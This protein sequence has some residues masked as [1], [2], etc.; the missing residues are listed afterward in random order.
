MRSLSFSKFD[1]KKLEPAI[2][3]AKN[4]FN[5]APPYYSFG[6]NDSQAIRDK[7]IVFGTNYR[8]FSPASIRTNL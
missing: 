4:V 8:K 6:Q 1:I 7:V 3:N 5:I 2:K